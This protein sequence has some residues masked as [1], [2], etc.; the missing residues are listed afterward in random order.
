M[1]IPSP[2]TTLVLE[3]NSSN[4]TASILCALYFYGGVFQMKLNDEVTFRKAVDLGGC[5]LARGGWE[6]VQLFLIR[7]SHSPTARLPTNIVVSGL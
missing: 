1:L 5:C 6:G 3:P 2:L 4:A 7:Q